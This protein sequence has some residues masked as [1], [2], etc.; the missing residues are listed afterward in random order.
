M[1]G[2]VSVGN[3]NAAVVLS[4]LTLGYQRHPAVHHVDCEIEDGDLIALLGPNGAG[5]TTLLRGLAGNLNPLGGAITRRLPLKTALLPQQHDIDLSVPVTVT[6]TVA[7][8]MWDRIGL[9]GGIGRAESA[10]IEAALAAVKLDSDDRR[11]LGELSGGTLQRV[12]FARL[13][14]RD[15]D[16]ILLDEPFQGVDSSTVGDLLDVIVR[17]HQQG[18]TVIVS[19]HDL[20]IARSH[21]PQALLLA[22]DLLAHGECR[23]IATVE[24]IKRAC[25]LCA[26]FDEQAEECRKGHKDRLSTPGGHDHNVSSFTSLHGC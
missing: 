23:E 5:K 8:G 26:R 10:E 9:L 20:E 3:G 18:K 6:E 11:L 25:K 17:W 12:L 2:D 21:F 14:L 15:A 24:N 7:M 4:D 1:V 13:M 16:L 22:R 19:L